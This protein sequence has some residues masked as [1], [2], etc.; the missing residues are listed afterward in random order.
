[1]ETRFE[2]LV[3][4]ASNVGGARTA[5]EDMILVQAISLVS[6]YVNFFR[7]VIK[8]GQFGSIFPSTLILVEA[9]SGAGKNAAY[10]FM[11]REIFDPSMRQMQDLLIVEQEKRKEE[12]F[13]DIDVKFPI[14]NKKSA[15]EGDKLKR[16]FLANRRPLTLITPDDG[17]YEGFAF[18]RAYMGKFKYGAPTVRVDEYGDKLSIMKKT[19]Y[20]QNFYNRLLELVDY[21]VLVEK[22]VKKKDDATPGSKGMGITLLFTLSN[23]TINQKEELRMAVLKSIGRRGFIIRETNQS[24]KLRDI[25]PPSEHEVEVFAKE[26]SDLTEHLSDTLLGQSPRLLEFTP[27][28]MIF[29][30]E[31]TTKLATLLDNYRRTAT[32]SSE[33]D[34]VCSLMS[35]LDRKIFKLSSLLAIFNH[36]EKDFLVTEEDVKQA[37]K[38]VLRTFKSAKKFFDM[39]EYDSVN[40][41]IAFL[42][43][44]KAMTAS[45]LE[46]VDADIFQGI[47][48]RNFQA[49]VEELM[50]GSIADEALARGWLIEQEQ[51]RRRHLYKLSPLKESLKPAGPVEVKHFFSYHAG[52]D[53]AKTDGFKLCHRVD[54]LPDMMKSAYLYSAIDFEEGYRKQENFKGANLVILDFDDDLT[55]DAAK[56]LFKGYRYILGTTKSHQV[57]KGGKTVDRFRVI[58]FG[59]ITIAKAE[60]FR[61][62]M[63]EILTEFNSDPACKDAARAYFGAPGA[64]VSKEE[65]RL[66]PLSKFLETA[67]HKEKELQKSYAQRKP[68]ERSQEVPSFTL[69]D[70]RGQMHDAA[71]FIGMKAND[72][73][74]TP[75]R[76]PWHDDG[77]A[78]AF[79][80]HLPSGKMQIT[81]VVCSRTEF[82]K[83]A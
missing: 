29:Y 35:D 14:D 64:L 56:N 2:K 49:Q 44:R 75:I 48:K 25:T 15:K 40:K 76:C 50:M 22:S 74:T 63:K 62:A 38:I 16:A 42:Q 30:M 9:P 43:G 52:L 3:R 23:P 17:S 80:S 36:G 83:K 12:Y 4:F 67:K 81:C 21:D 60:D 28:A 51:D 31:L 27:E 5:S 68:E 33:K 26:L 37:E 10:K 7:I 41:V 55:I 54:L 24:L 61:L 47:T 53:I 59:D 79:A 1:M 8:E 11:Q 6:T 77:K 57:E 73:S 45:A 82:I 70:A 32:A 72:G 39:S 78:S 20:L 69:Y 65:G 71:Y 66:F 34:L 58:L 18:D 13:N 19:A 46:L